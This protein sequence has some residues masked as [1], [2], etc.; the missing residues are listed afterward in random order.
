MT[1]IRSQTTLD[2]LLIAYFGLILL[3]LFADIFAP[4]GPLA[5]EIFWFIALA[6]IPLLVTWAALGGSRSKLWVWLPPFWP[7]GVVVR[8][9]KGR[10]I[11]IVAFVAALVP[12]YVQNVLYLWGS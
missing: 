10:L 3:S 4:I 1:E 6:N 2:W 7:I 5:V 12:S 8:S 11:V 9:E